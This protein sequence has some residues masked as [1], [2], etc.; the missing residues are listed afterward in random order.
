MW[1]TT[2]ELLR[3]VIVTLAQTGVGSLG[4]AIVLVS[5]TLRLALLPLT[6]RLARQARVQQQ[7]LAALRPALDA[8]RSRHAQDPARLMRETQALYRAHDIRLLSPGGL[9]SLL[10]QAPIFSALF[11]ATRQGLG[12]RV[13]YL[14]IADL[15]R[16]DAALGIGVAALTTLIAAATSLTGSTEVSRTVVTVMSTMIGLMTLAFLW[17][18]SSAVALSVGAGS[19]TTL[20]QQ[21]ILTRETRR[22]N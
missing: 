4:H 22:A 11:A 1:D 18:T 3:G 2:V 8:L 20:I 9:L 17:S 13:R 7:R 21:A 15:A 16:P 19:M 12:E 14:W 6:L 5:F 10:I